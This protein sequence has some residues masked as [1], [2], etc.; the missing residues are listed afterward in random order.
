MTDFITQIFDKFSHY[1]E[2]NYK[3]DEMR[4]APKIT[5]ISRYDLHEYVIELCIIDIVDFNNGIVSDRISNMMSVLTSEMRNKKIEE[6]AD[7]EII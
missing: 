6:I 4:M 3:I 2:I 1:Y 7:G 5:F